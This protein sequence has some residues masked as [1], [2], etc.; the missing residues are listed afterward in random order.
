[1]KLSERM[2][3]SPLRSVN[4]SWLDAAIDHAA[5]LYTVH[6]QESRQPALP[7][8]A[9]QIGLFSETLLPKFTMISKAARERS[10]HIVLD[11]LAYIHYVKIW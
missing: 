1:M 11:Y 4:V 5:R 7:A 10:L 9:Y 3:S 8:Y 2:L 6:A